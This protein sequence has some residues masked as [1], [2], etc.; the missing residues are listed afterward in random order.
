MQQAAMAELLLRVPGLHRCMCVC[1]CLYFSYGCGSNT[2]ALWLKP[3]HP[4]PRGDETTALGCESSAARHT[5]G[6]RA[7]RRASSSARSLWPDGAVAHSGAGCQGWRWQSGAAANVREASQGSEAGEGRRQEG[8]SCHDSGVR[9]WS[10]CQSTRTQSREAHHTH[11]GRRARA[12]ESQ[13]AHGC[14]EP[15]QSASRCDSSSSFGT[16]SLVPI[17]HR[18]PPERSACK[19]SG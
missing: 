11:A 16:R 15:R 7:D 10:P 5:F 18:A 17:E 19:S 1:V 13:R 12:A 6:G 14:S 4:T 9:T 2:E 8:R 3:H